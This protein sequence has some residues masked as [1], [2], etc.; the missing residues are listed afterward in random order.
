[1]T[2]KQKAAGKFVNRNAGNAAESA[3]R[4]IREVGRQTRHLIWLCN[5]EGT[6]GNLYAVTEGATL[7]LR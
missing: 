4:S 5:R 1:M 7:T 3:P 6:F 2:T